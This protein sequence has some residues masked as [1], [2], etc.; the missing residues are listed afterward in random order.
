MFTK[1]RHLAGPSQLAD[2]SR[3]RSAIIDTN[4]APNSTLPGSPR[5]QSQEQS[6]YRRGHTPASAIA[7]H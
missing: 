6:S 3:R 5:T 1:P 2:K 7:H 4:V